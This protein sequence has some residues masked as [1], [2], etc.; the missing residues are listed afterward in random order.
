MKEK[1]VVF[2]N[3]RGLEILDLGTN[4]GRSCDYPDL[5]YAAAKTVADKKVERG[6]LI[7]GTGIG[8]CMV[9]NKVHGVRAAVCNDELTARMSRSHN[10][11]NILCLASD[12]LSE[13]LMRRI[14]E[15]WLETTFEAGG[16][17]ARRVQ[18]ITTVERG[19][20]P[21]ASS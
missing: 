21:R 11:A 14:V 9:A 17:H 16:R 7:C 5:A 6:I 2:L 20:D 19:L 3:E 10:D 12:V 15:S 18:K 13:E 4:S 8:M 1:L